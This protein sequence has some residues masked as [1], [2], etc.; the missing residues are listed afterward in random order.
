MEQQ[1]FFPDF[2]Y[3]A[4]GEGE[5][6]EDLGQTFLDLGRH[7]QRWSEERLL[8]FGLLM[9]PVILLLIA[10]GVAFIVIALYLPLFKIGDIIK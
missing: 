7:Y 2:Y 3:W 8:S 5:R 9:E 6:R 1:Y 10:G 4:I